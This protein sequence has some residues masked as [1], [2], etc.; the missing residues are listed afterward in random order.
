M[1]TPGTIPLGS[2][3]LYTIPGANGPTGSIYKLPNGQIELVKSDGSGSIIYDVV[4]PHQVPAQHKPPVMKKVTET[5]V[6]AAPP[7]VVAEKGGMGVWH[8]I[9]VILIVVIIGL[10]IWWIVWWATGSNNNNNTPIG[11][12]CNSNGD[13]VGGSYC[14]ST[15]RVCT[16]TGTATDGNLRP[17]NLAAGAG[18]VCPNGQFCATSAGNTN[19]YCIPV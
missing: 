9:M 15:T 4:P 3:Y 16:A 11:G 19:G 18:S 14:N 1:T 13:C 7:I 6:V 2:S 12:S 8:W 17:C 5:S 10:L